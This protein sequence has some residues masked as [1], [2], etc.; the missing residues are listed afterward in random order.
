M[1]YWL[2][3]SGQQHIHSQNQPNDI[4]MEKKLY[5]RAVKIADGVVI[6]DENGEIERVNG[7]KNKVELDKVIH[8]KSERDQRLSDSDYLMMSDYPMEDKSEWISYRQA[9]RDLPSNIVDIDN[10]DWPEKP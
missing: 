4:E 10:I 9:L 6:L 2:K 7:L 1:R 3:P 8:M 5:E